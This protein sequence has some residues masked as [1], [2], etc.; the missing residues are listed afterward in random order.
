MWLAHTTA[1]HVGTP[2]RRR[3]DLIVRVRGD[4]QRV[5]GVLRCQSVVLARAI[6][7]RHPRAAAVDA[8]VLRVAE[9][10]KRAADPELARGGFNK[11]GHNQVSQETHIRK[12]ISQEIRLTHLPVTSI[13]HGMEICRCLFSDGLPGPGTTACQRMVAI[14]VGNEDARNEVSR[15]F[16]N[17]VS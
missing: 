12:Q 14:S 5:G 11:A 1:L 17:F 13:R 10:R 9:R 3:L 6:G 4:E 2:S 7:A 15:W 8:T 16:D